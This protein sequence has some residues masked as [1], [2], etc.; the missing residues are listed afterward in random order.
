MKGFF[1]FKLVFSMVGA[2]LLAGAVYFYFDKK[3]FLEKAESTQGTVI[4]MIARR[5]DN[6]TTYCPVVSFKTKLGQEITFTSSISSNPPSYTV[7]EKVKILYDPADPKEAVINGFASLWLVPLILSTIGTI[8]FLIGSLSF[9]FGYLKKRKAQ[10][11][12]DTGKSVTAKF[13]QVQLNTSYTSNGRHPYQILSQWQ[14][15]KT[16]DLYVFKSD[17]IWFDPTEFVKTDTV[18]VFIDPENPSKY[19]VDKTNL[20]A[21]KN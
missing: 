14:D 10:N 18:R 1:I 8:F 5:S 7:N 3:I 15:P 21:L 2:G 9:L 12:R 19:T 4:E 20:P 17:Y 13:T 6:S 11:L 16:N